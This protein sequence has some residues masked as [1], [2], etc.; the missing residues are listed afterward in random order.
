[1]IGWANRYNIII[2]LQKLCMDELRLLL[3][4]NEHRPM[5]VPAQE[6]MGDE[7]M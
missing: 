2:Y 7:K 5:K 1:M 4:K 6:I 3:M